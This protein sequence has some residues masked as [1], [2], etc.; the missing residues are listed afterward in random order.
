MIQLYSLNRTG[1]APLVFRGEL[2]AK[3]S[4]ERV[5]S[6]THNRWHELAIYRTVAGSSIVQINYRTTWQNEMSLDSAEWLSLEPDQ[7]DNPWPNIGRLLSHYQP[8]A[9]VA[10]YPPTEHYREKQ[11]RLLQEIRQR[12]DVLV[13]ELL[14]K[15][16]VQEE[17][18]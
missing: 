10:G 1:K 4:G 16:G 5:G 15:A 11:Q 7:K 12:Y 14:A 18:A 8:T 13:S 2:V 9:D 6:V 17:V 3:V